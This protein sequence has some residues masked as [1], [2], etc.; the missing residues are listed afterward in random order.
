MTVYAVNDRRSRFMA[1]RLD[2]SNIRLIRNPVFREYAMNY[3][4]IYDDFMAN[5]EEFGTT[6]RRVCPHSASTATTYR[7]WTK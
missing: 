6:H 3:Q 1:F 5:V 2:Q 4:Q 7:T